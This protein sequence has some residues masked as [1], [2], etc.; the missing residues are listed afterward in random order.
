MTSLVTI[1][2]IEQNQALEREV[3]GQKEKFVEQKVT[4]WKERLNN[5]FLNES[6]LV[7]LEQLK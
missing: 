6:D 7:R 4:V 5:E 2:N 1:K 3:L